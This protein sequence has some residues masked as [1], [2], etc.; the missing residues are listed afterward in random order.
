[1][2]VRG[3]ARQVVFAGE[4]DGLAFL[5]I[6]RRVLERYSWLLY[7][8][9]LMSNHYHLVV[10][11]PLANVS[12]G[13]R[14]LNGLY[15]RR[16][17]DC[18]GREGHVFQA[19]FRS[20]LVDNEPYLLEV[21]RYVVLNPVRAGICDHPGEWRWSSFIATAGHCESPVWLALDRLLGS[22]AS[23]RRA[24]ERAYEEFVLAGLEDALAER[25][26]GERLGGDEF[27]RDD[28]GY[29]EPIPEVP[30]E[31]WLPEPPSL[32]ELFAREPHPV[33]T[34]YRRYGYTLREIGTY[35]GCHY[36]T[37]SRALRREEAD[38]SE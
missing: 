21:C 4:D 20:I 23:T 7:A 19:R 31:Q 38:L 37:V 14:Q 16:F 33:A 13:M 24:A 28:F 34:A 12:L 18:H 26:R 10:E 8:Y 35:L 29:V 2:I 17:N 11:T 5:E 27:V 6:L 9:C 22:F 36:A 30:R 1:V 25:V 15:A 3:N 32:E